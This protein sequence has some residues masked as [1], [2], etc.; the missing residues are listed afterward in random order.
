MKRIGNNWTIIMKIRQHICILLCAIALASCSWF[1][2]EEKLVPI[3][4][5]VN[6]DTTVTRTYL[7]FNEDSTATKVKWSKGDVLHLY[8]EVFQNGVSSKEI[9]ID[10]GNPTIAQFVFDI[11]EHQI[12]SIKNND[13][14]FYYGNQELTWDKTKGRP[15]TIILEASQEYE[16]SKAFL[17]G[18]NASIGYVPA[19]TIT[20]TSKISCIMHNIF[21]ILRVNVDLSTSDKSIQS[22]RI[23]DNNRSATEVGGVSVYNSYLAGEFSLSGIVDGTPALTH[24]A[25]KGGES[26]TIEKVIGGQTGSLDLY[27]LVPPG[28]L[29]TDNGFDIAVY[30]TDG[31]YGGKTVKNLKT[32]GA[33]IERSKI[34]RIKLGQF[35]PKEIPVSLQPTANSYIVQATEGIYTIPADYKGNGYQGNG[36]RIGACADSV[37][38]TGGAKAKILWQTRCDNTELCA[39]EL[40]SNAVYFERDGHHFISFN[41]SGQVGNALVAVTNAS[42]EI[43]WSWHIWLAANTES[44]IA[45]INRGVMLKE[46]NSTTVTPSNANYLMDRNLGA[47]SGGVEKGPHA[48]GLTYQYGRKD[49]FMHCNSSTTTTSNY[50]DFYITY[51]HGAISVEAR[52]YTFAESILNPCTRV[53]SNQNW[54]SSENEKPNWAEKAINDTTIYYKTLHDPCPVGWR[55]LNKADVARALGTNSSTGKLNLPGGRILADSNGKTL[56]SNLPFN[57]GEHI[58]IPFAG[59]SKS[60]NNFDGVGTGAYLWSA[61]VIPG[62]VSE[63]YMM[64][65]VLN[66]DGN[67]IDTA[68]SGFNGGYWDATI[69][70][71]CI[72]YLEPGERN[73]S[74]S[75]NTNNYTIGTGD[76]W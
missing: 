17:D 15:G 19:N 25:N 51:P 36:N 12:K 1:E 40:I 35:V 38:I 37:T 59:L 11:Y 60:N 58:Y 27:F 45:S 16:R 29:C 8:S 72:R 9:H 53:G 39:T 44:E 32:K 24:I 52:T 4:V 28:T 3:Y 10:A 65:L 13:N 56:D 63:T 22:V 66:G 34:T 30:T 18:Q 33:S 71:R 74:G 41:R 2:E 20:D 49:P 57:E 43:L 76:T 7:E 54:H 62:L 64:Q 47:M 75:S 23:T 70:I 6:L 26:L 73:T 67:T 61:D 21:G 68:T 48:F 42:G 69:P 31:L 46:Q 5:T 55:V 50:D 14:Y